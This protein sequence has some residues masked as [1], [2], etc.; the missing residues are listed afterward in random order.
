MGGAAAPDVDRRGAGRRCAP[1]ARCARRERPDP[2]PRPPR[3]SRRRVRRGRGRSRGRVRDGVHRARLHRARGGV[4]PPRRRP[5][6]D[7]GDDAVAAHG[8]RRAGGDPR[9]AAGRRPD[10]ADRCRRRLREQARSFGAA[11]PGARR[12]EARPARAAH[13]HPARVDDVDDQ[14][15]SLAAVP[16]D[17][18]D[19][20]RPPDGDGLRG[21]VRHRRVRVVGS[22]GGEPRPRARRW[23][24]R[25]RRLP[26]AHGRRA[27]E[28]PA[29]GGVPRVRGAAVDD[30]ARVP[31]RRAR[32]CGRRRPARV[33]PP[34]R[35]H[36][37]RADGH[38]SGVRIGRRVRGLPRR[39]AAAL[40]PCPGRGGRVEC[41]P[42][43]EGAG[44]RPRRHVVRLRQHGAAE[45]V[46][47][48][49]GAAAGRS[50][51][52]L[53]GGGRHGPGREH[54]DDPDLRR[55]PRRRH[56]VHRDARG[57]HR[58]DAGRREELRV[59]TDV[60]LGERDVPGGFVVAREDA[61]AGR[62]LGRG[63]PP[64]RWP[65]A[66]RARPRRDDGA[67]PPRPGRGRWRDGGGDERDLRPAHDPAGRGR[68]GRPLRAVRVRG[69]PRRGGR[70]PGSRD[71]GPSADHGGA[72]RGACREPDPDRGPD[73]GRRGA[74]DRDGADGGVPPRQEREPARLPDP[75][76]RR[77]AR[78]REHPGG[79][80][81]PRRPVR[82]QGDRGALADPDGS[83]DPQRDPRCRRRRRASGAG[84][85]RPRA[86]RD[87]GRSVRD[88]R[89]RDGHGR[90]RRL[91]DPLR[92][93]AGANGL[94]RPLRERRGRAHPDG[95]A[96][97]P[98][99]RAVAG[100]GA[101]AL[102][103]AGG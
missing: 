82:R 52:P 43:F 53:P 78:G 35:A 45:P 19:P 83:G 96:P 75:H 80:G 91:P 60:R 6:R 27:H 24:I 39:A 64:A 68:P 41:R 23:A 101:R 42:W 62:G 58:H 47:D 13:L 5:R 69:A 98:A 38:G 85:A 40:R 44:R 56:G 10:R 51:R 57:G 92:D 46:D 9:A 28:R 88:D 59:S 100:R 50:D 70:R 55:R 102:R 25:L 18:R 71:G 32:R 8:S 33:P 22:D 81:R 49:G 76:D 12:V 20:R 74:G 73:R 4:R 31:P 48:Q 66:G 1:A 2:R 93:Q 26:R 95:P 77:R 54:R 79:V 3:R 65:D 94:V 34:Q 84:D 99:P 15:T 61:R 37:W 97:D 11:V 16:A 63:A 30:R 90:L 103:V 87:R 67:G 17:R 14:A 7:P 29:R 36:G 89:A 72:R 86:R 21:R